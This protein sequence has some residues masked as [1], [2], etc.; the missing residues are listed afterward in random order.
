MDKTNPIRSVARQAKLAYRRGKTLL[1]WKRWNYS[2]V[3]YVF[4]NAI[5]KSGSHLLLQILEGLCTIGPFAYVEAEPI[6]VIQADGQKLTPEVILANLARIRQGTIGW[7]YLPAY[8]EFVKALNQPDWTSYFIIR[9]PRD[10]LISQIFYATEINQEHRLR[11]YY[12]SL[13]DMDSR[14]RAAIGGVHREG[15]NLPDILTRYE[16]F[17]G[18]FNCPDVMVVKFE[19]LLADQ[20]RSITSMIEFLERKDFRLQMSREQAVQQVIEAVQPKKSPTFRKGHSGEWRNYF[21]EEHKQQFKQVTGDL[22]VQM[23]YEQDDN[24]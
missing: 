3:P 5:P 11:A 21:K 7:G 14:L 22:L 1:E 2:G 15:A 17:L 20:Q 23:G 12:L 24:W 13:P 19:E 18:W 4:G 8:P 10:A 6:R 16:R 9:D